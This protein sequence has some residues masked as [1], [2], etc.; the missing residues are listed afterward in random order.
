MKR[1]SIILVTAVCAIISFS[2]CLKKNCICEAEGYA[3]QAY[4]QEVLNRYGGDG[5]MKVVSNGGYTVD[6]TGVELYCHEE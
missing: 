1:I 4:L 3:S 2:A 6:Y 5:C